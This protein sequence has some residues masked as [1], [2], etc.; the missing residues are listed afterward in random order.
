M[1][2][3]LR[4][5]K[6]LFITSSLITVTACQ[7]SISSDQPNQ[8][9]APLTSSS[10]SPHS[11]SGDEEVNRKLAE[12][13][14]S[15]ESDPL[16]VNRVKDAKYLGCWSSGDN[17]FML[18]TE[19]SL[20]TRN[21]LRPLKYED[22]TGKSDMTKGIFLL[23]I[24]DDDASHEMSRFV[25]FKSPGENLMDGYTFDSYE[26]FKTDRYSGKQGRWAKDKCST[27]RKFLKTTR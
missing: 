13:N 26:D 3:M 21:S 9:Q 1:Q 18:I 19:A 27:I 6:I 10:K 12:S 16:P 15:S 23:K 22:V 24:M 25:S 11:R 7:A 14:S 20:Q 2:R 5:T 4:Y 17:N 8:S